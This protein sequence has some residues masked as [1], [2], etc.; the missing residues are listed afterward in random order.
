MHYFPI[1][2]IIIA[3]TF[4]SCHTKIKNGNDEIVASVYGKKLYKTDLNNVLY[5]GISDNDSIIRTRAFIEEWIRRQLLLQQAKNNLDQNKI[6]LKKRL[7][8]YN[9]SLIIY[10]YESELIKQNLDTLISD[11]EIFDY[12]KTNANNFKLNHNIVKI[13]SVSI[14]KDNKNKRMFTKLLRDYDSLLMD[15]ITSMAKKYAVSYDLNNDEWQRFDDV[16]NLYDLKVN[17]QESFLEKNKFLTTNKDTI[18]NLIRICDFKKI[19]DISPCEIE[20]ETIKYIIL[21]IRKKKLL[22]KLYDDLYSK[23]LKEGTFEIY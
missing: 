17:N 14:L 5:K 15:S 4:F 18:F 12:Y 9:N 22:E 10:I 8:E 2:L 7:E 21:N 19:G 20:K 11:E 3:L 6:N 1:G 13:I 23:A 16:I